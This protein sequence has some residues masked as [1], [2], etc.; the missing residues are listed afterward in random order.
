MDQTASQVVLPNAVPMMAVFPD[1]TNVS[2]ANALYQKTNV[3]AI[4]TVLFKS[5]SDAMTVHV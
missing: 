1:T 2:T 3:L 5:L 4:M